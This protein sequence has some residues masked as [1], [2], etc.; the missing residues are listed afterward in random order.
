[1]L[2]VTLLT[3]ITV[4]L[5][6]LMFTRKSGPVKLLLGMLT[7]AAAMASLVMFAMLKLE[8]G[9]DNED[10][11]TL[12]VPC[13]AYMGLGSIGLLTAMK[14]HKKLKAE[15][16]ARLAAKAAKAKEKKEEK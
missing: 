15:K 11:S 8:G 5:M 14:N 4:L 10:L 16:A 6:L 1:M 13:I 9:V 2:V 7:A 12:Y 3:V